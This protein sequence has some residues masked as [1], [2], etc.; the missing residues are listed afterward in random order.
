MRRAAGE[1][2]AD[3]GFGAPGIAHLVQELAGALQAGVQ[4]AAGLGYQGASPPVELGVGRL[5]R[6]AGG[7]DRHLIAGLFGGVQGVVGGP[8]PLSRASGS[9]CK[10]YE[11]TKS[12][13]FPSSCGRWVAAV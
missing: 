2:I 4:Q 9:H 5:V 12:D 8:D 1:G 13:N 3:G 6:G 11:P 7:G 10:G